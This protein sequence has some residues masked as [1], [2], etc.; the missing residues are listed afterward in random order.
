MLIMLDCS[1]IVLNYNGKATIPALLDSVWNQTDTVKEILVLDNCS[2]DGS[3]R[4]AQTWCAGKPGAVYHQFDRNIGFAR[5]MNWGIEH[6]SGNYVC[7]LNADVLIDKNYVEKCVSVMEDNE[8]VGMAGG[9][10]YRLA[11][12]KKTLIIDSLGLGLHRTRY[13]DDISAG[14]LAE[15]P[16]QGTSYP[17]GIGGCAPVYSRKMIADISRNEA[18]FLELFE[19][20]SEDLDL[21]WRARRQ[22]WK[23]VCTS[24]T[25]GWHVREGS[26]TNKNLQRISRHRNHRNRIWLMILNERPGIFFRHI[27]FW[28]PMQMFLVSK[29]LLQP[30]L[31]FAYADAIVHLPE[32]VR[33]RLMR[34]KYPSKLSIREE[35]QLFS[36][37]D[38]AYR[39]RIRKFF[40]RIAARRS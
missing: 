2:S 10:L 16:V 12:G 29:I 37:G 9:V 40:Q 13:H 14:I 24:D 27:F 11:N 6:S 4:L 30:R 25:T 33:I 21:A 34:N 32:V 28:L 15:K 7:L 19:S 17:F 1:V 20:Y 22:G 23:A 39:R 8:D 18:P 5:A 26:V 36:S 3:D 35:R 31:F 38:G